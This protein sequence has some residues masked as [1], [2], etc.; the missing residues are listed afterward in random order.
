MKNETEKSK[1]ETVLDSATQQSPQK[2]DCVSDQEGSQTIRYWTDSLFNA[3]T[4]LFQEKKK[5]LPKVFQELIKVLRCGGGFLENT[6][7]RIIFADIQY[8]TENFQPSSAI[9]STEFWVENKRGVI[10]I[11]HPE[12]ASQESDAGLP[13]EETSIVDYV[14]KTL[15]IYLEYR[16]TLEALHKSKREFRL[17]TKNIPALVFRGYSDWAVDLYDDRIEKFIG[18]TRS[19]FDSRRMRWCDIL[20]D[21]DYSTAKQI[22]VDALKGNKSYVRE[23]RV[24]AKDGGIV[25]FQERSHIVCNQAG[26][27]EYVSGIFFDINDRKRAEAK[28]KKSQKDL[29]NLV[30]QRTNELIAANQRLQQDNTRLKRVEAELSAKAR[31]LEYSNAELQRLAQKLQDCSTTDEL[32]R[33]LNRRGFFLHAEQF[34]STAGRLKKVV[35]V[36]FMDL[37]GLKDINDKYGHREGDEALIE[38][39]TIFRK[40]FRESDII[41][42]LGGDEFVVLGMIESEQEL[43][44]IIDRLEKNIRQHN[45]EGK[46]IFSL[47]AS[48]GA[49]SCSASEYW[50]LEEILSSADNLM[51]KQK[52][53]KKRK[54]K[55]QGR[56][57]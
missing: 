38:I 14:A 21:K 34:F 43:A 53:E 42:R 39:V 54:Q 36:F 56:T 7:V 20:H 32:T 52:L 10:E 47:S 37:D 17:M 48:T 30:E 12:S 2:S 15:G 55:L 27:V 29:E 11:Y 18:Y 23:F 46:R 49:T 22:F 13:V 25:W 44:G 5:S 8:I 50:R 45:E 9:Y 6:A 1:S 57:V 35:A 41:A 31:E 16:N 24:K 19:D 3:I 33:I 26:E 4:G 51:Y 40:T 28:L